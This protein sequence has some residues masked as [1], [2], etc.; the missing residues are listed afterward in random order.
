MALYG[1]LNKAATVNGDDKTHRYIETKSVVDFLGERIQK[2][3]LVPSV[4]SVQ[5][6]AMSSAESRRGKGYHRFEKEEELNDMLGECGSELSRE[7][8]RVAG[9]H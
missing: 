7:I 6:K 4:S 8:I 5:Y 1:S 3:S 9:Y 2:F